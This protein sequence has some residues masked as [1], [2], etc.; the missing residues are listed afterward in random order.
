MLHDSVQ[1]I[2][3]LD[4]AIRLFEYWIMFPLPPTIETRIDL[5]RDKRFQLLVLVRGAD[6]EMVRAIILELEYHFSNKIY[7]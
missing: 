3:L 7:F 4:T 6:G 5:L 1:R 2:H